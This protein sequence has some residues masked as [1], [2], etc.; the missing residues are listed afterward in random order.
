MNALADAILL[1]ARLDVVAARQKVLRADLGRVAVR[2]AEGLLVFWYSLLAAEVIGQLDRNHDAGSVSHAL[3]LNKR[4]A[5]PVL[6]IASR[7]RKAPPDADTVVIDGARFVGIRPAGSVHRLLVAEPPGRRR[8]IRSATNAN[9]HDA[10]TRAPS[11]DRKGLQPL[12]FSLKWKSGQRAVLTGTQNAALNQ[13]ADATGKSALG[14]RRP[15]KLLSPTARR[16][17]SIQAGPAA[18]KAFPRLETPSSVGPGQAFV[19]RAGIAAQAQAGAVGGPLDISLP[20]GTERFDLELMVVADAVSAATP[21]RKPG[22]LLLT[23]DAHVPWELAKMPTPL[24]TEAPPYLG[25]QV[26]IGRWPLDDSGNPA[27]HPSAH[28]DVRHM[29]V[30]VGDYAARSGWRKL[31]NAELEGAAISTR[32]RAPHLAAA[33]PE[34]KQ[35]LNA[36]LPEGDARGGA[37]AVHFACHGEAVQGHPLNAAEILDAGQHLDPEYLTDSPLGARYHPFLFPNAC[38]VGKAGELLG[39]FSGFAGESLKG[40][41][42]GF[43]AP[44]WSVDDVIA[45]DI[46]VKFY[47]RVFGA[48]GKPPEAVAAVLRDLRGRFDPDREKN[49]STR[50]AYVS[51]GHPGLTLNRIQEN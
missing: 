33:A 16:F 34:I 48:C 4:I 43:L 13:Q 7:A 23:A 45:H 25:C 17:H 30:V 29:A 42:S 36:R 6:D 9:E 24:D 51:Y 38:Q 3:G 21:G 32:Y 40:G 2:R 46:A 12:F 39:S 47:E 31:E 1:D 14:K 18:F 49:S 20:A 5:S 22:V 26:D 10:A 15:V 35:L 19:L 8:T 41:F 28:I 50:L 11:G 27:L 44:L 37:E